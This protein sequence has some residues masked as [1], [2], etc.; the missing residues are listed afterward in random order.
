MALATVPPLLTVYTPGYY[1][2]IEGSYPRLPD[3]SAVLQSPWVKTE[4]VVCQYNLWYFMHGY[5][6]GELA[7]AVEVSAL[8]G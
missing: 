1:A 5:D 8:L 3:H 7:I 4:G 6:V 2:Y